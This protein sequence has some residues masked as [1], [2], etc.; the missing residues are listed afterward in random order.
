MVF[1]W[2]SNWH[3]VFEKPARGLFYRIVL[4]SPG[5]SRERWDTIGYSRLD[6]YDMDVHRKIPSG[7]LT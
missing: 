6:L 4:G 1:L 5:I 3:P 2:F 7:S